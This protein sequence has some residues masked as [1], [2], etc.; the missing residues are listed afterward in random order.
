[1]YRYIYIYILNQLVGIVYYMYDL[2]NNKYLYIYIKK[3]KEEKK[4]REH[5]VTFDRTTTS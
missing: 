5:T 2:Q 4:T 3:Q 1:M